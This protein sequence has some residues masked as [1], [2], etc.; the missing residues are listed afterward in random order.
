MLLTISIGISKP[1]QNPWKI[2][3]K[4]LSFSLT[5]KLEPA[6]LLESELIHRSPARILYNFMDYILRGIR[7]SGCFCLLFL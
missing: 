3:V 6:T 7:H 4:E 2:P 5:A 1:E